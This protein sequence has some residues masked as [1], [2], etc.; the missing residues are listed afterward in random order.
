MSERK[1]WLALA[2][3]FAAGGVVQLPWAPSRF[4]GVF[5]LRWPP[6]ARANG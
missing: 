5:S 4:G 3:V 6:A 1:I 2:A